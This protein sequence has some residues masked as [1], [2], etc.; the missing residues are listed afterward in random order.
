MEAAGH[1]LGEKI[2]DSIWKHPNLI[3][4]AIGIFVYVGAEVSIGSSI[5]N[6]LAL[7]NIGHFASN[8]AVRPRDTLQRKPLQ[9]DTFH[10]IGAER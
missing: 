9:L 3:F 4:G 1:R 6:Y 2:D 10:C 5:S 7:D 8:I